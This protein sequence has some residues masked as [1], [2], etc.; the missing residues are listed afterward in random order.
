MVKLTFG[1]SVPVSSNNGETSDYDSEH[2]DGEPRSG[3][4][5]P[6]IV[7]LQT[8]NAASPQRTIRFIKFDD[9]NNDS[10]SSMSLS[11]LKLFGHFFHYFFL[12][13]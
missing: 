13:F 5:Y 7:R 12:S 8:S 4:K 10:D 1:S 11:I 3:E 2:H 9:E 6:Q